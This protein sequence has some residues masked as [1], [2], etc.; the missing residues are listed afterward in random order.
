MPKRFVFAQ[1][2]GTKL[3][4]ILIEEV[5][6]AWIVAVPNGMVEG[7]FTRIKVGAQNEAAQVQYLKLQTACLRREMPR[8]WRTD[9]LTFT[10]TMPTLR[11]LMSA[12]A[13]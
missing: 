7:A 5:S 11:A 8:P 1:R 6:G 13:E 12:Y 9:V 4:G 10:G 2:S 3:E